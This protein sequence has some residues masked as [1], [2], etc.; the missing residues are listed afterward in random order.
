MLSAD[1]L[2]AVHEPPQPWLRAGP[3]RSPA[4]VARTM[5]AALAA[6]CATD[7]PPEFLLEAQHRAF[8]RV[9]AAIRRYRGA[10]LAEPVGSGKTWV[11]LAVAQVLQPEQATPVI[12]PTAVKSHWERTARKLGVPLRFLSTTAVSRGHLPPTAP[13][14]ILDES[15]HFR[16]RDTARYRHVSRW[17]TGRS[18][19]L[20]SAT[21]VVNRLGDLA[22]QLRLVVRDDALAAS[23]VGSLDLLLGAGLGDAALADLIVASPANGR[24]PVA[25]RTMQAPDPDPE[26]LRDIDALVLARDAPVAALLRQVLLRAVGSSPAALAESAQSYLL[27][28]E[29]A[30]QAAA[31]GRGINRDLIRQFAGPDAQQCVMWEVV[32]PEGDAVLELDDLPR[33]RALVARARTREGHPDG[34][35]K[36]LASLLDDERPTLVFTTRRATVRYLRDHLIE[37]WPAWCAGNRAGLGPMLAPRGQVLDWFRADAPPASRL[38]SLLLATDVAAEGIDLSRLTRVVHYDLPWTPARMEQREGRSRRGP[39]RASVEAW[40]VQPA[41]ALAARFD[42]ERLLDAKR[43]LPSVV[44]VGS[45]ASAL[46]RWR[47]AI[48]AAWGA[49]GAPEAGCAVMPWSRPAVLAVLRVMQHDPAGEQVTGRAVLLVEAGGEASSDAATITSLLARAVQQPDDAP[50]TTD[51]RRCAMTLVARHAR[52]L[53]SRHE[54]AAWWRRSTGSRRLVTRLSHLAQEA[55]KARDLIRLRD[56]EHALQAA[57]AG[58]SAGEESLARELESLDDAG[59]GREAWRLAGCTAAPGLLSVQVAGLLV[60]REGSLPFPARC[61]TFAAHANGHAPLRP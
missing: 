48:A 33:V 22:A 59:L 10:L 50:P 32:A 5:A 34:K 45:A 35:V 4:A 9:L 29:H 24:L 51:E 53:L 8:R 23:G 60:L 20:L 55:R 17:L 39:A 57:G 28:L 41:L 52:E 6:D 46:W 47:E 1:A 19:L 27:L 30:A 49:T 15:H 12:A 44:D 31:S 54:A 42:L 14:A 7:T 3:G 43:H 56:L 16:T 37:R 18:A 58:H 11:A 61:A 2:H 21:P 13:L 25:R 38:P 36:L 40:A 26:F